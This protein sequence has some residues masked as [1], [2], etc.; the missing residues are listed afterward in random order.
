MAIRVEEGW[1]YRLNSLV[2][3]AVA[4]YGTIPVIWTIASL[5]W[6]SRSMFLYS[7]GV[8]LFRSYDDPDPVS[9][10]DV[11]CVQDGK[12]LIWRGEDVPQRVQ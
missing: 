2:R 6:R 11:V 8:E 7:P 10:L 4:H 9:D 1:T 3:N 5:R 12:L